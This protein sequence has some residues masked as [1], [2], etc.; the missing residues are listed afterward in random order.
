LEAAAHPAQQLILRQ[1]QKPLKE[2]VLRLRSVSSASKNL[3]PKLLRRPLVALGV[4]L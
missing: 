3:L 4:V 2:S 1:K